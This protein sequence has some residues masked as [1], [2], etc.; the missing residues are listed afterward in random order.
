[1]KNVNQ[2]FS[3]NH[4]LLAKENITGIFQVYESWYKIHLATL[5]SK[6]ETTN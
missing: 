2:L 3:C 5:R 4:G 1:M 6:R